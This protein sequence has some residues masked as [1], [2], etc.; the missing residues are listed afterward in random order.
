MDPSSEVSSMA[1]FLPS[2]SP[3]VSFQTVRIPREVYGRIALTIFQLVSPKI[4]EIF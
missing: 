1:C 4:E 3:V 2:V